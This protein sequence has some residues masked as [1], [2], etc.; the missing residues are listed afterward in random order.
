M[1]QPCN[2]DHILGLASGCYSFP[3]SPVRLSA[4][5]AAEQCFKKGGNLITVKDTSILS[6][7]EVLTYLPSSA[8]LKLQWITGLMTNHLRL[9]QS[10]ANHK[11]PSFSAD[12]N[13]NPLFDGSDANVT[14]SC[15]KA[16]VNDTTLTIQSTSCSEPMAFVCEHNDATWNVLATDITDILS[17]VQ[18][19]NMIVHPT[20]S[21]TACHA[22]C[23]PGVNVVIYD[24]TCLCLEKDSS[25]NMIFL[26][27]TMVNVNE[28]NSVQPCDGNVL[29]QCGCIVKNGT[30]LKSYPILYYF[31]TPTVPGS[32]L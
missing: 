14:G 9:H 28:C 2:D 12:P 23:G 25:T 32:I 17:N 27:Q 5:E 7:I 15:H 24:K 4:F 30:E 18:I 29:Q 26:D 11:L 20:M 8:D 1:F 19:D 6:L 10:F 22:I 21:V 31:E 16:T 3:I 13:L